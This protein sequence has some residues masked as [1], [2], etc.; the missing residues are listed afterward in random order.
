[1]M[2]APKVPAIPA[3]AA[4]PVAR[5]MLELVVSEGLVSEVVVV[6][7]TGVTEIAML[8]GSWV[9]RVMVQGQLVMVRVVEEDTV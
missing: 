4:A 3:V 6:G 5:V 2:S 9:E 8:V 1:M 7:P